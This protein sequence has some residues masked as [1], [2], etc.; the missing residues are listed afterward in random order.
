LTEAGKLLLEYCERILNQCDEACKAIEDL[1][2]LK[3]GTL[4]IG[5]SQTTGTYLM[6]RMIGYS[7]KNT[8]MYPFNFKFI[9]LEELVGV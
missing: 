3:G 8:L 7:D 1:N 5:A 2:S 6:P 9:V 4:V